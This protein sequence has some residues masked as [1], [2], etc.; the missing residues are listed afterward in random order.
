M[1]I[2]FSCPGCQRPL[3]VADRLAGKTGKCPGCGRAIKVPAVDDEGL[4]LLEDSYDLDPDA[5]GDQ[6]VRQAAAPATN[7]SASAAAPT[8]DRAPAHLDDRL[9][10]RP[11]AAQN[12]DD[13]APKPLYRRG[14]FNFNGVDITPLGIALVALPLI[15][16]IAWWVLGPGP[17]VKVLAQ[18]TVY[19]VDALHTGVVRPPGAAGVQLPFGGTPGGS[20]ATQSYSVGKQDRLIVTKPDAD[21][22]HV[23]LTISLKQAV[24][25]AHGDTR[26]NDTTLNPGAFELRRTGDA[27]GSGARAHL[28]RETFT[29]PVR[30]DLAGANTSSIDAALPPQKPD[31]DQVEKSRGT[32]TG[33]YEYA[34]GPTR[35]QL[36]VRAQHA[37][38]TIPGRT[39]LTANGTVTTTHPHGGP[40]VVSDYRGGELQVSW[41][42]NSQAQWAAEDHW[43]FPSHLSPFTR[44]DFNLLFERPAQEGKYTLSYA[45]QDLTTVKLGRMKQPSA[46]APSPIAS[47]RTN[48]PQPQSKTA[49]GP[50]AYFDV[51]RDTKSRAEGLFS[52]NNMRQLGIAFMLYQ[53]QNRGKFPDSLID[54]KDTM[55]Q[56][57]QLL[58]NPRTGENP[59]FIYEKPDGSTPL[60]QTPILWESYRG[61]KDLSGAILYGDGSI[62]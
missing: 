33:T 30:I 20:S 6:I 13:D 47:N 25:N 48:G 38:N 56:V 11:G 22:D 61:Q 42:P 57:E 31:E 7:P 15:A 51:V 40:Q 8:D 41:D 43:T 1:P 17:A 60:N 44:H 35:G 29:R 55:P 23:L 12:F 2:A 32:V 9:A 4:E 58:A 10:R 27:P 16:V 49:T 53:D 50:G 54:F 14:L 18:N 52:A 46:P 39:G 26:G 3:N 62:R 28:I 36:E 59:G 34:F 37:W 19:T 24:M 21:G 5:L 45:G